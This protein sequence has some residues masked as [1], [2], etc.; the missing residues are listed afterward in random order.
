MRS[1]TARS[2][3][4]F[5][6]YG[7]SNLPPRICS[8]S[9][10]SSTTM[11]MWSYTGSVG[12]HGGLLAATA[13]LAAHDKRAMTHACEIFG[14]CPPP[15][16]TCA[17]ARGRERCG[18]IGSGC[19]HIQSREDTGS[20]LAVLSLPPRF[21]DGTRSTQRRSCSI[22]GPLRKFWAQRR[23]AGARGEG[24]QNFLLPHPD[25]CQRASCCAGPRPQVTAKDTP[26]KQQ[27]K[28]L[29]SAEPM[30]RPCARPS[31]FGRALPFLALE[32]PP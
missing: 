19:K 1:K 13:V 17:C 28:T 32:V 20:A 29:P 16:W 31:A 6:I 9:L 15:N 11:T 26:C 3:A 22:A 14:I 5:L 27:P 21:G 18:S 23:R 8:K 4:N 10:F 24:R 12:G 25:R 30:G 7:A 2:A